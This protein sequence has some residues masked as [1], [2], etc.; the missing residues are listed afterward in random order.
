TTPSSRA[1][2]S[3]C[4]LFGGPMALPRYESPARGVTGS[5]SLVGQTSAELVVKKDFFVDLKVPAVL[6]QGDRPR[7]Q[8]RLHHLGVTGSVALK[9]SVYAGQR[10]EVYPRTLEVKGDGVDEVLFEAYEWPAGENGR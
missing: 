6:T 8:A 10:E 7:F 9:L 1:Q 4:L 5:D 3:A 2:G